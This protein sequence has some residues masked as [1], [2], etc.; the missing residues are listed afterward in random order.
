ML[1]AAYGNPADARETEPLDPPVGFPRIANDD[2]CGTVQ[3][4]T[5]TFGASVCIAPKGHKGPHHWR[6][7]R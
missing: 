2:E 4:N 5:F 1:L 7:V 3:G 6:F